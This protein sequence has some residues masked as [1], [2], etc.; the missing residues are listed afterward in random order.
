[1]S[2]RDQTCIK[3]IQEKGQFITDMCRLLD[4]SIQLSTAE[5]STQQIERGE[6]GTEDGE[7]IEQRTRCIR[8]MYVRVE[9]RHDPVI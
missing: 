6:R 4:I 9:N 5:N 8:C 7:E 3:A 2:G 1:M